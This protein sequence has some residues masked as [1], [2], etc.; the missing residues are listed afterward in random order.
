MWNLTSTTWL[1]GFQSWVR[2]YFEIVVLFHIKTHKRVKWPYSA[3]KKKLV[4]RTCKYFPNFWH[5][6]SLVLSKLWCLGTCI[7]RSIIVN[8]CLIFSGILFHE[9]PIGKWK[10]PFEKRCLLVCIREFDHACREI[11]ALAIMRFFGPKG[12]GV[13]KPYHCASLRDN[14]PLKFYVYITN[15]A[16]H[17]LYLWNKLDCHYKR[18]TDSFLKNPQKRPKWAF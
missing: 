4:R 12:P 11:S 1:S 14:F 15:I 6:L 5:W 13:Y 2:Q 7:Y 18:N 10:F 3:K 17:N 16:L 8:I 9:I